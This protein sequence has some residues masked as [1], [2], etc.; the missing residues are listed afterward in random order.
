MLD[1]IKM[2]QDGIATMGSLLKAEA[3]LQRK[4]VKDSSIWG[5]LVELSAYIVQCSKGKVVHHASR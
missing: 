2:H 3:D 5:N 1:L 4:A